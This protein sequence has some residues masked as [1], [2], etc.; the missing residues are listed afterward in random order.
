MAQSVGV[1]LS[2][3]PGS[4]QAELPASSDHGDL[5]ELDRPDTAGQGPWAD[6]E[7]SPVLAGGVKALHL[8]FEF[9]LLN[10][11]IQ[12]LCGLGSARDVLI[13]CY[14]RD[15]DILLSEAITCDLRVTY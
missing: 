9:C 7:D 11:R 1:P 2:V 13:R 12:S 8:I 5:H 6:S 4:L 15:L 10:S 14:H 3:T